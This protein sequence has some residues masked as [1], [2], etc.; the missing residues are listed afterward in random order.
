MIKHETAFL[1]GENR[2]MFFL[3]FLSFYNA[4]T[5]NLEDHTSNEATGNSRRNGI[6]T[7]ELNNC[8]ELHK[9]GLANGIC[10]VF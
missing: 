10:T 5:S 7:S 4:D 1:T 6:I 2:I 3:R 9:N 8:A